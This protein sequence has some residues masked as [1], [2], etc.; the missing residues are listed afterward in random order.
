MTLRDT[1]RARPTRQELGRALRASGALGQEWAPAFEAVD[2]AAFLPDV[3]WPYDMATGAST[4][5]DRRADPDAWYAHADRDVPITTQWD[6]GAHEGPAPGR[7]AT[8]SSS[9]PSIV[10]RMLDDL[11]PADGMRVLEIGTGTGWTAGLM[12]Y[13]LGGRGVTSVEVDAAVADRARTALRSLDL[14]PQ[15][16]TADGLLGHPAATPYDRTIAT[17]GMRRI[18]YA[19]IEQTAPGGLVVAPWG[20]AYANRDTVVVLTVA[21]DGRSASGRFRRAVEF[22]KARSQRTTRPP[23]AAYLPDGFPGDATA[24]TT[25]LTADDGFADRFGA[26]AFAAGLRVPRC[27]W[28]ADERDGDHSVW[29]YGLDGD[30]SWAAVLFR[31]GAKEA[32]VHQSGPRGLWDEVA[33][34]WQW[35]D[36]AGRPAPDRF[37]LTVTRE[38]AWAWLDA[39]EGERWR[40]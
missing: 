34:A 40:V 38:G 26:F 19:W 7:V 21:P 10:F 6:D 35:W 39:A 24:T 30:R 12:A 25:T 16:L 29:W 20:T 14:A 11:A 28:A 27:A 4:T 17:C 8:S 1:A 37:G 13:R 31:G 5:V 3:M 32:T 33:A 36:A 18:P 15:V 2:R 23:H 9:M 22:M